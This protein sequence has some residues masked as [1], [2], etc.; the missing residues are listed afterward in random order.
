[1]TKISRKAFD[2]YLVW[3]RNTA[4]GWQCEWFKSPRGSWSVKRTRGTSMDIGNG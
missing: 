4:P 1:M 3:A 2:L